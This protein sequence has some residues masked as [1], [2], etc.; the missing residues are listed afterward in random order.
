MRG[1]VLEW[2]IDYHAEHGYSPSVREIARGLGVTASTAHYHLGVLRAEGKVAW[3]S[4][5]M[6]TLRVV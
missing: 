3:E 5:Q 2:L 4:G 1:R 6:R